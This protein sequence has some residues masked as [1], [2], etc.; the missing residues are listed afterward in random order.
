MLQI[1]II[2]KNLG[3]QN[4]A[5]PDINVENIKIIIGKRNILDLS[6]KKKKSTIRIIRHQT[7]PVRNISPEKS[8][9]N[10]SRSLTEPVW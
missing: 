5:D 6:L 3:D 2:C 10:Y 9:F 7:Y 8:I 1:R 4:D